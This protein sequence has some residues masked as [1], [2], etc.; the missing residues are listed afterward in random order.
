MCCCAHFVLRSL[1]LFL[2]LS[3][4]LFLS[5][6]LCLAPSPL[7]LP[8]FVS[9][10]PPSSLLLLP[11]CLYL[12]FSLFPSP[13]PLAPLSLCPPS[14]PARLCVVVRPLR[15]PPT[16]LSP[17]RDHSGPSLCL[18]P[19]LRLC[20][21]MRVQLPVGGLPCTALLFVLFY[22]IYSPSGPCNPIEVALRS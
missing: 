6:S 20:H 22:V 8:A 13:P 3:L 14:A 12:S 9:L 18:C 19:C 7:S 11:L 1:S 10:S 5:F 17:S 21:A 16:L 2:Y 4:S 15:A